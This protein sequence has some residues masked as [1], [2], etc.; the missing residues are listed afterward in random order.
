M[1]VVGSRSGPAHFTVLSVHLTWAISTATHGVLL[2]FLQAWHLV[3][4]LVQ[5][6]IL[7]IPLDG[8]P[9]ESVRPVLV[10]TLMDKSTLMRSGPSLILL[11]LVPVLNA[12][13]VVRLLVE[14]FE[15]FDLLGLPLQDFSFVIELPQLFIFQELKLFLRKFLHLFDALRIA[16]QWFKVLLDSLKKL[17]FLLLFVDIWISLWLIFLNNFPSDLFTQLLLY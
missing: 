4:L 15:A 12:I 5:E 16:I 1:I 6:A 13:A 8:H 17:L 10:L 11:W 7:L 14:P 2:Q 3:F 9:R